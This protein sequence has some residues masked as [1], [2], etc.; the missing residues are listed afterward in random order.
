LCAAHTALREEQQTNLESNQQGPERARISIWPLERKEVIVQATEWRLSLLGPAAPRMLL[1]TTL[2]GPPLWMLSRSWEKCLTAGEL[3]PLCCIKPG[4]TR[5]NP[6]PP[7]LFA[8][9][10]AFSAAHLQAAGEGGATRMRTKMLQ[11]EQCVCECVC[12]CVSVCVC[13][14]L[15]VCLSVSLC[16]CL[17]VSVWYV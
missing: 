9:S 13:V 11:R 15:S 5:P 3:L 1:Q 6:F 10:Q 16:V 7:V 4:G 2:W 8:A 17:C 12:V 14:C